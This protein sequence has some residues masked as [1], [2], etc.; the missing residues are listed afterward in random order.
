MGVGKDLVHR[1]AERRRQERRCEVAKL[2]K[3]TEGKAQALA[4][5]A[6]ANA[7]ISDSCN[8]EILGAFE[9]LKCEK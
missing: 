6:I 5:R 4:E 9:V 1:S 7:E 2:G 3:W 8:L